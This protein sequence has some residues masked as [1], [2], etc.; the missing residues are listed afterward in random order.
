MAERVEVLRTAAQPSR[1]QALWRW[2]AY[3]GRGYMILGY[4]LLVVLSLWTLFPVYWQLATSVRADV[5]LYSSH[6][7]LLPHVLTLKHYAK[8]FSNTSAFAIQL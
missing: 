7:T 6:V 1:V 2:L 3:R 4:T 5:D 8:I